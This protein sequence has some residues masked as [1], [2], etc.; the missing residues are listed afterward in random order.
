MR[1]SIVAALFVAA[2][3]GSGAPAAGDARRVA[4]RQSA[5]VFIAEPTLIGNT[6]VSGPVLFVHDDGGMARGEPCTSVRLV[7]PA[8]GPTEEIAAFHCIPRR[9][10]IVRRFTLTTKPH[11]N[12]GYG[13]VLI[14]YQFAGDPEI[15]GVPPSPANVH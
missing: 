15:H 9:G 5:T 8:T 12:L 4:L 3:L 7:D 2:A 10:P 6:I 13:C 14:A 11:V 1:R